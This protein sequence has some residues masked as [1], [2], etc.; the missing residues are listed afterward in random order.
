MKK[1][2]LFILATFAIA[3]FGTMEVSADS[4]NDQ[5]YED[6]EVNNAITIH[7]FWGDGCSHCADMKESLFGDQGSF[8]DGILDLPEYSNVEIE[9]Y[10]VWYD[11][12]ANAK[13]QLVANDFGIESVGVP[14][15]IIGEEVIQGYSS[16]TDETMIAALDYAI[17]NPEYIDKVEEI[18]GEVDEEDLETTAD[19]KP[20]LMMIFVVFGLVT[21]LFFAGRIV[22]KLFNKGGKNEETK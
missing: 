5:D 13:L 3:I 12:V 1:V 20:I 10:E 21:A 15:L 6:T 22:D 4:G 8:T 17:S 18:L 14:L 11:S 2:K 19:F 16:N 9:L 7:L